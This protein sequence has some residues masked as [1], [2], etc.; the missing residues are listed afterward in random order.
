M[1]FL[2]GF[3]VLLVMGT[4]IKSAARFWP[5][6]AVVAAFAPSERTGEIGVRVAAYIL[7][8]LSLVCLIIA[9]LSF[10]GVLS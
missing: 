5:F 10:V 8:V 4:A 7:F 1:R 2:I 6:R 3:I 9:A